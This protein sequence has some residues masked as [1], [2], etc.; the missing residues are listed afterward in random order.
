MDRL[1]GA[2]SKVYPRP[3]G[4]TAISSSVYS[5]SSGLSPPTRGNHGAC[6]N[7]GG[8]HGSIPAHAGEPDRRRWRSRGGWV[9]PRPRGGTRTS[10]S[11]AGGESGLS[12]PTR[13]NPDAGAARMRRVGSIPAHAGEP[14]RDR[15]AR[16]STAVYPR[17][18]GGTRSPWQ[19]ATA[20]DGL[21]PPTW[22]N[23]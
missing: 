23:R 18:R 12:P 16:R 4:G 13:G 17:P 15:A 3:R 7:W 1:I 22:G 10:A 8:G 9:Y 19:S 21:S 5:R 2:P 14:I 6:H 11:E 20:R